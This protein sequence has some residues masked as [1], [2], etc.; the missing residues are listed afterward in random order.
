MK[1]KIAFLLSLAI[2][3][4]V[5]SVAQIGSL[6]YFEDK[7]FNSQV[8]RQLVSSVQI[9]G[10]RINDYF[11]ERMA[12]VE[13]VAENNEVNELLS[14]RAG[15]GEVVEDNMRLKLESI[16]GQIKIFINK[17]PDM[18][19]E[20]LRDDA[21][22]RKIVSQNMGERSRTLLVNS[23]SGIVVLDYLDGNVGKSFSEVSAGG[24]SYVKDIGVKS[25]DGASLGIGYII[26]ENEFRI[27]DKRSVFL[28]RFKEMGGYEDLVLIDSEGFVVYS[29]GIEMGR[30]LEF[31]S[32]LQS[33]SG[34]IYSLVKNEKASV[35]YGPYM[36]ESVDGFDMVLAFATLTQNNDV[37][38]LFSEMDFLN[39]IVMEKGDI[40]NS[41]KSYLINSEGVLISSLDGE[42]EMVQTIFNANG[43]KCF[44]KKNSALDFSEIISRT[45]G[46][47]GDE[48]IGTYAYIDKSN[49]CLISEVG[50]KEVFDLP[51]KG[52]TKL[53]VYFIVLFN[54]ALFG[55]GFYFSKKT[56]GKKGK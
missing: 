9:K 20:E 46:A 4:F 35:I 52:K 33:D 22:F 25:G 16:S 10:E 32:N 40:G 49:W 28:E 3:L 55:L 54:L 30:G 38:I 39:D 18:T 8:E 50:S 21:D 37:A 31:A 12:D 56:G 51:K 1:L 42:G 53:D 29:S 47:N 26:Y 43:E 17:Y 6:F 27:I 45:Y 23:D 44:A 5:V 36:R 19:L 13:F 41:G 15:Y 2:M 48:V 14:V 7:D 11:L 34:K 24:N